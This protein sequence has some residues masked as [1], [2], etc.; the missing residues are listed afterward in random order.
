MCHPHILWSRHT[1]QMRVLRPRLSKYPPKSHSK[2]VAESGPTP[3]Q[4]FHSEMGTRRSSLGTKGHVSDHTECQQQAWTT[5]APGWMAGWVPVSSTTLP[6]EARLL[7]S[8]PVLLPSPSG[9]HEILAVPGF[10]ESL[11]REIWHRPVALRFLLEMQTKCWDCGSHSVIAR[12]LPW[13]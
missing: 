3:V 8:G 12:L 10:Q 6:T 1:L 5:P 13:R 11:Q 4:F 9:C 7:R 2:R